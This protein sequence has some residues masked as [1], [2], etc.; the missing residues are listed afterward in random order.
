[1]SVL[2]KLT[3]HNLRQ[4]RRRTTFTVLGVTLASALML[5]VVGM[6]T[7]LQQTL[8]NSA[9]ES[10]GNYHEMYENVP[11]ESLKYI[12]NNVNV[13][14]YF[15]S[16]APTF[17][18]EDVA[19]FYNTNQHLVYTKDLYEILDTPA[20]G[21][22]NIFVRFKNA[23]DYEDTRATILKVVEEKAGRTVNYRTNTQLIQYEGGLSDSAMQEL[24][25]VGAIVVAI[26]I[27]TSIFTIRNSFSISATERI[28][29]FG[30]LSSV[31]ATKKQI[32][33]SVILEGL[34]VWAIGTPVGILLGVIVTLILS[35]IVTLLLGDGLNVP[36]A[37]SIPLWIFL[38]T[39]LL[40]LITVYFSALIPAIKA[41]KISP[42]DAIRGNK[43]VKINP[44]K[45]K[46]SKLTQK[47]FGV[48]GVIASKNLKRSRKKYRTTVVSI[49]LSAA[50]FIG[51]ATF[52]DQA[53]GS[54]R[55]F[56]QQAGY[57]VIVNTS[58]EEDL[59]EITNKF[60]LDEFAYYQLAATST[61]IENG[62]DVIIVNNDYFEEYARGLGIKTADLSEV[63]ILDDYV[64]APDAS[65]KKVLQHTLNYQPGMKLKL[66]VYDD[67]DNRSTREETLEI[68]DI[69]DKAPL[70]YELNMIPFILVSENY[71][72]KHNLHTTDSYTMFAR[73]EESSQIAKF[74]EDKD[75]VYASDVRE[76]MK[77]MNNLY[78]LVAIFLYG[79]IAVITLIGITNI[80][81]TISANT[82]LRAS[83][84]ASLRSVG[85]TSK[86]FNKMIRLESLMYSIKALAI[87]IPI[88]LL[89][90]YGFYKAMS[91]TYDFGYTLPLQ[92]IIIAIVAVAVL[93]WAIMRYSVN[94]VNKQDIIKTIRSDTV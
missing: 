49:V 38:V 42:V 94:L 33:W 70:G 31:G 3:F 93:I 40:S 13:E 63:A 6:V 59:L 29:Q 56:Y 51:L 16:D 18:D 41:A 84:F 65:G 32:R 83:D 75:D 85:M 55:M 39:L 79:F 22:T 23:V 69:T 44:K 86:E 7:S 78:L 19:G 77:L 66:T 91:S 80:L 71:M 76:S 46:T 37:F 36:M 57:D 43:E 27:I 58:R 73:T 4:N 28:K 2:S 14:S 54:I 87:G 45:I 60:K 24:L 25:A 21:T 89:I 30:M 1:M 82:A 64:F 15:Y 72:K 53:F 8:I 11:T 67:D 17:P 20:S 68:T 48:G 92:A 88:G 50:T 35:Q 62:L 26:I 47:L 52:M 81:N 90:S 5:A 10:T 34:I 74:V 61:G 12:E 9:I